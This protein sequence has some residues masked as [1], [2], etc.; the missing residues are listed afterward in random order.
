MRVH[1]FVNLLFKGGYACTSRPPK[2]EVLH[3]V[4][5]P[6]FLISLFSGNRQ[7]CLFCRPLS[8]T[9]PHCPSTLLTLTSGEIWGSSGN[10]W[11]ALPIHSQRRSCKVAGEL[12]GAKA[13]GSSGKHRETPHGLGKSDSLP[14]THTHTH[15][16]SLCL[17]FCCSVGR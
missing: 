10:L 4:S 12:L 9:P 3:A 5:L 11:I 2:W 13:R 7:S 1:D 17:S 14:V 8:S 6:C 15:T 16:N